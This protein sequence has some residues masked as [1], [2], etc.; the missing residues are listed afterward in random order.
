MYIILRNFIIH[1]LPKTGSIGGTYAV[2]VLLVPQVAIGALGR[3][4]TVPRYVS[5]KTLLPATLDE[6]HRY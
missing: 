1:I 6:I 2:P 5:K 3:V 4:Q